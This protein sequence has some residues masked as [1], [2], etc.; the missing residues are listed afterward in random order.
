MFPAFLI[1][2]IVAIVRIS[3]VE[4]GKVWD[5]FIFVTPYVTVAL[6]VALGIFAVFVVIAIIKAIRK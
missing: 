3:V 5:F 2:L 1:L 6:W 4:L